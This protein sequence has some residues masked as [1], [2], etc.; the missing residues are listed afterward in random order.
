MDSNVHKLSGPVCRQAVKVIKA[1]G[2][3]AFRIAMAVVS[4]GGAGEVIGK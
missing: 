4:V 3:K 2:C 1:H